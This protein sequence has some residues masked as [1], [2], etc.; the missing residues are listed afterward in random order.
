MIEVVPGSC[1]GWR[2]VSESIRA[3]RVKNT[4]FRRGYKFR[5]HER[6]LYRAKSNV[7]RETIKAPTRV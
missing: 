2:C 4:V 3:I 7:I 5:L 1:G 6:D